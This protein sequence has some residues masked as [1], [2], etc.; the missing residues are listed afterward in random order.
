[1]AGGPDQTNEK[2][3]EHRRRSWGG[4]TIDRSIRSD[5]TRRPSDF[6]KKKSRHDFAKKKS[7]QT[8]RSA[9]FDQ[10]G[11]ERSS[12]PNR[13]KRRV[14]ADGA[15]VAA[16]SRTASVATRF[17]RSIFSAAGVCSRRHPQ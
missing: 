17:G 4:L 7:R 2:P 5:P 3:H 15:R 12:G 1:V 9:R 8:A 13:V 6:A 14:D 16:R 11:F 10:H